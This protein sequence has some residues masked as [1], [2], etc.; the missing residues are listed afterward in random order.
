[1]Q[2]E[3]KSKFIPTPSYIWIYKYGFKLNNPAIPINY[4]TIIY[5]KNPNLKVIIKTIVQI[6]LFYFYMLTLTRIWAR[7]AFLI[8]F[9]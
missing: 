8:F 7:V 9:Y 5:T 6:S 1:M 2:L 4:N 3:K